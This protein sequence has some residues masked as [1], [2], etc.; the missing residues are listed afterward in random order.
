MDPMVNLSAYYCEY[1]HLTDFLY[2]VELPSDNV[3][4]L[5]EFLQ[6]E[7][8]YMEGN[9]PN[10]CRINPIDYSAELPDEY[11]LEGNQYRTIL[12]TGGSYC[13]YDVRYT[14]TGTNSTVLLNLYTNGD[15]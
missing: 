6:A 8:W 1:T 14:W 15:L 9:S 7:A 2:L 13:G 10:S 4:D 5:N 12:D 11:L 3:V